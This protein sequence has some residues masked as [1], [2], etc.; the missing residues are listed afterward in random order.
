MKKVK[1]VPKVPAAGTGLVFKTKL[2]KITV[3]LVAD[4]IRVQ[5]KDGITWNGVEYVT[6]KMDM[7]RDGTWDYHDLHLT[8]RDYKMLTADS[9]LIGKAFSA[10]IIKAGAVQ[11]LEKAERIN[12]LQKEVEAASAFLKWLRKEVKRKEQELKGKRAQLASFKRKP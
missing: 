6:F 4:K 10:L 9:A 7:N 2:G 8:R 3:S 5:A 11:K 1:E 12:A